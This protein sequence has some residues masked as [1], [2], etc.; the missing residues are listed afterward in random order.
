[1]DRSKLSENDAMTL[2][3]SQSIDSELACHAMDSPPERNISEAFWEAGSECS[4]SWLSGNR[5][6]SENSNLK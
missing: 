5:R 2:P 3:Q 1:M 4:S 6:E